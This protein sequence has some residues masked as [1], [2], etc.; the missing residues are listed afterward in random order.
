MLLYVNQSLISCPIISDPRCLG[1]QNLLQ[2]KLVQNKLNPQSRAYFIFLGFAWLFLCEPVDYAMQYINTHN[3][4]LY[5]KPGSLALI[6]ITLLIW[7]AAGVIF[8]V[9]P[10]CKSLGLNST[11]SLT[12]FGI[13]SAPLTFCLLLFGRNAA[14]KPHTLGWH[15]T[16]A[17]LALASALTMLAMFIQELYAGQGQT[18]ADLPLSIQIGSCLLMVACPAI[19]AVTLWRQPRQ[20]V[21]HM[22]TTNQAGLIEL[23]TFWKLIGIALILMGITRVAIPL[24]PE[25][26]K[27][28]IF[29]T[30]SGLFSYLLTLVSKFNGFMSI[31]LGIFVIATPQLTHVNPS[32]EGLVGILLIA[33]GI[34]WEW[35]ARKRS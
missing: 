16:L 30:V 35:L 8:V 22:P 26:A 25:Y 32:L 18:I 13:F 6:L 14:C 11:A 12:V 5:A 28:G 19:A 2:T 33:A 27:L 20:A 24:S 29:I 1:L 21:T 7:Y 15:R 23:L 10:R 31:L 17:G 9:I 34:R 4:E 3:P